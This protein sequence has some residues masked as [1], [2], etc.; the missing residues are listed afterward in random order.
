MYTQVCQ[1]HF[2]HVINGVLFLTM[3][4]THDIIVL[5]A[6]LVTVTYNCK[7]VIAPECE[8]LLQTAEMLLTIRA[9]EWIGEKRRVNDGPRLS[10]VCASVSPPRQPGSVCLTEAALKQEGEKWRQIGVLGF[11]NLRPFLHACSPLN[12]EAFFII[13]LFKFARPG[14][15]VVF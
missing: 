2:S 15:K 14:T 5:P 3:M 13:V 1:L 9:K 4:E 12:C 7:N 8:E 11:K 6:V 10:L